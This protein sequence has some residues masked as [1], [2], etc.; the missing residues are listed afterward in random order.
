MQALAI[1]VPLL[2]FLADYQQQTAHFPKQLLQCIC[3]S[4]QVR[5]QELVVYQY[6]LTL[7]DIKT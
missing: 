2:H 7:Q 5:E 6:I 1:K 4:T 3:S